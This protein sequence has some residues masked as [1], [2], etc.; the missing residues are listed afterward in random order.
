MDNLALAAMFFVSLGMEGIS[1]WRLDLEA[2]MCQNLWMILVLLS[3]LVS[4]QV[5]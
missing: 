3:A 1:I 4:G 2:A 5:S